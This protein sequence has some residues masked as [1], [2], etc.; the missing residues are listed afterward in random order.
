ML[1]KIRPC[2]TSKSSL[3]LYQSFVSSI[4][5]Y[6]G[7]VNSFSCNSRRRVVQRLENRAKSIIAGNRQSEVKITSFETV[8]FQKLCTFTF[9]CLNDNLCHNFQNYFEQI[10]DSRTRS[11]NSSIRLPRVR[12]EVAKK[13][14]YY[15][16]GLSFNR[17]PVAVRKSS[18]L[19]S[20]SI[21]LR[22]FLNLL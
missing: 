6:C 15:R 18:T 21:G 2:L 20:F 11:D 8:D 19:S 1:A 4:L 17:L 10:K 16:G 5:T 22:K 9:K 7:L 13:G 14:C 3:Q 12:L